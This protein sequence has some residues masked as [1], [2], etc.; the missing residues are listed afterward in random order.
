MNYGHPA[1]FLDPYA[2]FRYIFMLLFFTQFSVTIMK[3]ES[4]LYQFGFKGHQESKK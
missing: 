1:A 3:C 2:G 4:A